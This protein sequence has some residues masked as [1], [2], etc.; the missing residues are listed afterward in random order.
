MPLCLDLVGGLS[1]RFFESDKILR[2]N[3]TSSRYILQ[4]ALLMVAFDIDDR[5]ECFLSSK[6]HSSS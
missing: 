2:C 6:I 1:F 4:H 5:R 3:E